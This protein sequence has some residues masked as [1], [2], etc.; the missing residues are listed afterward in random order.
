MCAGCHNLIDPIG[1]GFEKFDAIGARRD[2]YKLVFSSEGSRSRPKEVLLDLDT[3][4]WVTG[5]PQSEFASPRG[6]GELLART[7]QCHE[8]VVKQVFRYM[9]GREDTPADR[10]IIHRTLER[11]RNAGFRFQELVVSLVKEQVSPSARRDD[12]GSSH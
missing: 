5:I 6:L 7:P 8:C 1:F 3:S 2:Q 9:A 10:P 12:N 11:F 4:A